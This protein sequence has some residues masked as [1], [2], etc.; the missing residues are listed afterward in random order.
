MCVLWLHSV[1]IPWEVS[2]IY[3]PSTSAWGYASTKSS[4]L[5]SMPTMYEGQGHDQH[6]GGP[7][8]HQGE[9]LPVV[10]PYSYCPPWAFNLALY[11]LISPVPILLF[12]RIAHTES[13]IVI[14]LVTSWIGVITQCF[15]FW[16]VS[17][18]FNIAL[19]NS[20]ILGCAIAWCKY[21]VSPM[22]AVIDIGWFNLYRNVSGS[23]YSASSISC[24]V[25]S[26]FVYFSN[27][28]SWILSSWIDF[29]PDPL[30]ILWS[31]WSFFRTLT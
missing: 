2:C 15:R 24:I 31:I 12:L 1:W 20:S 13:R 8:Y 17:N 9:G 29:V 16:W 27:P 22:I 21:I 7:L 3:L 6:Y 30:S 10:D 25:L 5:L 26:S 28:L 4:C 18:S 14:P 19:M 11:L 23:S